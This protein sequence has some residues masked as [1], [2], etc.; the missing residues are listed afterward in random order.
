LLLA[1]SLVG[2]AVGCARPAVEA[3]RPAAVAAPPSQG[4]RA[5]R[6]PSTGAFVEPPAGA[7]LA[8]PKQVIP[9]PSA[10]AEEAAPGGGRM[11]RLQGAFRSQMVGHI[12]EKGGAK[13]SCASA[14]GTAAPPPAG[15]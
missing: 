8:A 9:A 7:A 3:S 5:Y 2:A 13:I 4:L 12:D 14:P 11:V 1:A 15:R 10:L 6:D